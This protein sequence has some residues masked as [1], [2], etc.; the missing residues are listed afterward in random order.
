MP[1]SNA[2]ALPSGTSATRPAV[3][4]GRKDSLRGTAL[5]GLALGL[6]QLVTGCGS[7]ADKA[8]AASAGAG[9]MPP[10][11]VS[12]ITVQPKDLATGFDYVGQTAG[13]RENEVRARISGIL[14]NKLYEEGSRVK[15]GTA[16]FQ[17]DPG[18]YRTQLASAEAAAGVAQARVSQTQREVKRLT[19]LVA[20][21]A[22]S[23]KEFDDAKSNLETAE[24][25]QN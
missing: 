25:T 14:E 2:S 6:V 22:I 4:P 13:S 7:G 21:N 1:T 23:Q 11:E 24:A 3:R 18:A 19:P 10:P 16:L 12:V 15:A 8:Q 17:I 20:E 5:A 9:G